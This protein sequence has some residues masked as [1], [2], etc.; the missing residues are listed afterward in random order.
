MHKIRCAEIWGGNRPVDTSVCTSA[1]SAAI[2]SKV[3]D[4]EA[5]GDI[6]YFSVCSYDKLTRIAI[7]DLRGHGDE[8]SHLSRWLYDALEERMNT[9]DGAGVLT[10]LN[11]LVH[12]QGFQAITTAA[13]VSYYTGD[14]KLHYS[15]AGH[16]PM[17]VRRQGESW[18]SLPIDDA[19]PGIANLP[20]GVMANVRYDQR[21]MQL[22]PMDRLFLYTDGL[23][24]RAN[25]AGD[26]YGDER[27]T[28]ILER[29]GDL[30]LDAVKGAI[31][32][33]LT[34][35]GGG[36]AADDDC[37]LLVVEVGASL[38]REFPE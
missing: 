10:Q 8:A 34:L 33:D 22:Q 25:A 20:L 14:S 7:A 38:F 9:L 30:D 21:E 4:G 26:L 1:L 17:V 37:T 28:G 24:E 2:H 5:G 11:Q 29:T 36:Q 23:S 3:C 27:L 15:Y 18:R 6:Y 16:P 13:I 12:A 31:L 35:H 19:A 32:A